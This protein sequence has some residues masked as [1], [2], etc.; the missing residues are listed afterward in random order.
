[1]K[2]VASKHNWSIQISLSIAG[3]EGRFAFQETSKYLFYF[4]VTLIDRMI[5]S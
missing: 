4:I 1:V 3:E 5:L 2:A